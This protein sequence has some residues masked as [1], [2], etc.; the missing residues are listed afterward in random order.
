MGHIN[1]ASLNI[2]GNNSPSTLNKWKMISN[3]VSKN[4]IALMCIIK[5]HSDNKLIETLN[6]KH[7]PKM[8]FIHTYDQEK[9]KTK[10]ITILTNS[11]LINCS[12]TNIQTKIPRH[13]IQLSRPSPHH[14]LLN[15]LAIYTPTP[16]TKNPP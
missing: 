13:T 5:S 10:G 14:C 2:K 3:L 8:S 4:S 11:P 6:K 16:P 9:P 7:G 12:P 1:I 15:S